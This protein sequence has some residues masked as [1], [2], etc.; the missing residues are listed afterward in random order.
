MSLTFLKNKVQFN[1][2]KVNIQWQSLLLSLTEQMFRTNL[3]RGVLEFPQLIILMTTQ[4]N[5]VN[6]LSDAIL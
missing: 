1:D 6:K 2:N 3:L 5:K 4:L